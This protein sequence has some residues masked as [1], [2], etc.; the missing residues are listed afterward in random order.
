MRKGISGILKP[1]GELIKC[2]YGKHHTITYL[3]SK[4]EEL[5]CVFFSSSMN[6]YGND[7]FS[8]IHWDKE[9]GITKKQYDWILENQNDFDDIQF[10]WFIRPLIEP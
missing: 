1:N 7:E 5:N 9:I 4:E 10:K 2:E 8:A 6:V 3:I